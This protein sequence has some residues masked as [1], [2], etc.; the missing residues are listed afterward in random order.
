[1]MI[2]PEKGQVEILDKVLPYIIPGERKNGRPVLRPD[3]PEEIKELFEKWL[4][5]GARYS[6]DN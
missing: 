4:K 3:T 5:M 6:F 1:M 2:N